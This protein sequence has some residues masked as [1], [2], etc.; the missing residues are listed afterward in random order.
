MDDVLGLHLVQGLDMVST[1]RR[2]A[3]ARLD[4]EGR[5]TALDLAGPDDEIV[6]LVEGD[7]AVALV[8][9]APLEVPDDRGRRDVEAVLA[10]CDIT[11]FPVSLRRLEKVHG[12][13]RGVALAPALDRPGRALRETIPDA[14]LRQIA[15]EREHP[16]GTAPLDLADYRAAWLA[17]RAPVFRPKGTGRARPEGIVA[18]WRLLGEVLDLGGWAPGPPSDD[19]AAINDA[20]RIDALCCAFAARRMHRGGAHAPIGAPGH[21]RLTLPADANLAGRIAL[22][23][24]RL[25]GEGAIRI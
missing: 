21:G 14:V 19:W 8:V 17:V 10:W 22:T 23:V 1:P 20:A 5:L 16:A 13:A 12:G 25:R 9:D 18:A 3:L 4:D 15:W 6:A 24:E 2:S 11:A 7:D